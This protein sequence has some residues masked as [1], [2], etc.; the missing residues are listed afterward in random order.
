MGLDMYLEVRRYVSKA[1]YKDGEAVP[2]PEYQELV[3]T[4]PNQIDK[5]AGYAGIQISYPVAYWRK[6]NAI[7]GWFVQNI[8][9]GNDDCGSY[10]VPRQMLSKLAETCDLLMRAPVGAG[11]AE[12]ANDLLPPTAGFFFG[13]YE[14]DEYYRE[15]MKYTKEMLDHVLSIVPDGYEYSFYYHSSW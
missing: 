1:D 7:H 8:Q 6:A 5:Y 4:M 15:D 9:D 3:A 2:V 10:Y 14:V 13:T 11:Y 12:L